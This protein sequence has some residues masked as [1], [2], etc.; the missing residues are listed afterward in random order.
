MITD[1][2]GVRKRARIDD[3]VERLATLKAIRSI[4]ACDVAVLV[5]DASE[6]PSRQDIRLAGLIENRGKPAVIA[7]NKWDMA[8]ESVRRIKNTEEKTIERLGGALYFS[9]IVKISA[10]K[11]QRIKKLF[12]DAVS[13]RL[14]HQKRVPTRKLNDFLKKAVSGG[15]SIFRG[16]EFKAYYM[17][18]VRTEPPGFV[19]FTNATSAA[20]PAHYAKYIEHGIRDNFGFEG[21]PVRLFFRK[22]EEK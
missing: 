22:K 7:L 3:S 20:V 12:E 18:Q 11:G 2:A 14:S 16:R 8:P 5:I 6:G 17:T 4:A 1:T 10:L 9:R 15:P 21:T 19:I 13:A